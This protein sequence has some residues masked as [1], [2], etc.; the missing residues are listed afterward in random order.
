MTHPLKKTQAIVREVADTYDQ[1]VV[2]HPGD[3]KIDVALAKQQQKNYCNTLESL[4]IKLHWLKADNSLPDCC[5]TEDPAMIIDG[6]AVITYPGVAYRVEET[7]AMKDLLSGMMDISEIKYPGTLEGGDCLRI[8]KKIF[9]GDSGR[10]NADGIRQLQA[11]VKPFGYQVISVPLRNIL[12]LKSVSSYLGNDTVLLAEGYFDH[13]IFDGYRKLFVSQEEAYA[14]NCLTVNDTIITSAGF[15]KTQKLVE[16]AG[17][18]TLQLQM[19][20]FKQGAGS[21][22][23]L[24]ILF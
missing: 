20:E 21:L 8:D 13:S 7:D 14:T 24:S 17:F 6:H 16:D 1:A 5:F 12:H 18:K 19:Y 15:P 11:I 10:T 23:C 2:M 22:T 3:S 4:G 9:I